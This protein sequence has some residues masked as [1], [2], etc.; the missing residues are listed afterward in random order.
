MIFPFLPDATFEEGGIIGQTFALYENRMLT[1]KYNEL[2]TIMFMPGGLTSQGWHWRVDGGCLYITD[3]TG[4]LQFEFNSAEIVK[5]RMSAVGIRVGNGTVCRVVMHEVSTLQDGWKVRISS[6]PQY[7]K[8][9]TTLLKTLKREDIGKDKIQV[10][11]GSVPYK[12]AFKKKIGGIEH[13]SDT[14][15]L[16]GFTALLADS[17][18]SVVKADM[19]YVLLHDTCKVSNGFKAW[20]SNVDV[21]LNPDIILLRPPEEGLE[22]GIYSGE[23]L[24]NQDD[25]DVLKSKD[26]LDTLVDRAEVVL[27]VGGNRTVHEPSDPYQEK[28]L[29]EEI[30]FSRP[31]ISKMKSERKR[32]FK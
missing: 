13:I 23:F 9:L 17:K 14:R 11:V 10:V 3:D 18:D 30:V 22:L 31:R 25:L 15:N 20:L 1:N 28:R 8:A 4:V 32:K 27:V 7:S 26:M 16:R 12:D 24:L 21:G 19:R 6:C 5:G 29:R 2:E